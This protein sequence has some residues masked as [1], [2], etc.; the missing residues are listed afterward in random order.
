MIRSSD[1]SASQRLLIFSQNS[2]ELVSFLAE[3]EE[4]EA[5]IIHQLKPDKVLVSIKNLRLT[6]EAKAP[7]REGEVIKVKVESL[8][9][10]I[11]LKIVPIKESVEKAY[12]KLI[13]EGLSSKNLPDFINDLKFSN[14]NGFIFNKLSEIDNLEKLIK[15]ILFI[16]DFTKTGFTAEKI[17]NLLKNFSSSYEREI[18][19]SAESGIEKIKSFNIK[20]DNLKLLLLRLIELL[21]H[22][23][24]NNEVTHKDYIN[25]FSK[26]I[27]LFA[28]YLDINQ[29]LQQQ[30]ENQP[31]RIDIPVLFDN[32]ESI[33]KF[34]LDYK[35]QDNE[36]HNN[37]EI[38][39]NILTELSLLG[40]IKILILLKKDKIYSSI[41]LIDENIANF[42]QENISLLE[43]NLS[44]IGFKKRDILVNVLKDS[45]DE[46]FSIDSI[47][48]SLNNHL[49]D[50]HV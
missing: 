26:K 6:A 48:C 25:D 41:S 50:F 5:K 33:L 19:N 10:R 14:N 1:I 37:P 12:L 15:N 47:N 16:F 44:S 11:I 38:V 7:F 9:P 39:I 28:R 43:E 49:I 22:A 17:K 32:E 18:L 31:I 21:N 36:N 20:T 46:N 4:V 30:S 8:K 3:G 13:S 2:G 42:L 27:K 35:N 23:G 24:K 29:L 45:N 40:K 34:F